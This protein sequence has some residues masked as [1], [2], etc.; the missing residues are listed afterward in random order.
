[1]NG[2]AVATPN[3]R[4]LRPNSAAGFL[5]N[6]VLV[7]WARWITERE[8]EIAIIGIGTRSKICEEGSCERNRS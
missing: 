7:I 2:Y 1:M 8:R 6:G 5:F 3:K 4:N